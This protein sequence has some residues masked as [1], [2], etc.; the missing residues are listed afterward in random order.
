MEENKKANYR[1]TFHDGL[2]SDRSKSVDV[3]AK[4]F[5]EAFDLAYKMP[6]ARRRLYDNIIIEEIPKEP[7]VIGV[8]YEY[9]DTAFGKNFTDQVFIKAENEQQAIDYYNKHYKN[10]RFNLYG[11]KT[12]KDGK[13]IRGR[14]LKTYFTSIPGFDADATVPEK[15]ETLDEKISGAQS[16]HINEVQH[17]DKD[18]YKANDTER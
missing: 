11:N 9:Y 14:I 5:D 13:C 6:E 1:I 18:N 12:V 7:S 8:K 17:Q 2:M 3:V 15:K 16:Q 4:D 10:G